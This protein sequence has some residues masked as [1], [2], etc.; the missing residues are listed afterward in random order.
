MT[1]AKNRTPR[2]RAFDWARDVACAQLARYHRTLRAG[3]TK[4][5]PLVTS[6]APQDT[7]SPS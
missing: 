6:S 7:D 2:P 3:G 5:V 4:R 1:P